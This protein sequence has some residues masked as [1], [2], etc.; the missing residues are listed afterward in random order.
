M[1]RTTARLLPLTGG[2]LLFTRCGRATAPVQCDLLHSNQ[3][4]KAT[5]IVPT[6]LGERERGVVVGQTA[7]QGVWVRCV[8]IDHN[9]G[10]KLLHK[11]SQVRRLQRRQVSTEDHVTQGQMCAHLAVRDRVLTAPPCVTY[12]HRHLRRSLVLSVVTR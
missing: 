4:C 11:C 10:A 2:C 6:T 7:R 1:G 9:V 5:F 3:K 8:S 12:C